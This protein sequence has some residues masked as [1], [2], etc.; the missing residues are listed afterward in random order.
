MAVVETRVVVLENQY[1]VVILFNWK[2]I[3]TQPGQGDMEDVFKSS[4]LSGL[5]QSNSHCFQDWDAVF[6]KDSFFR[7]FTII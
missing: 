5:S 6:T 3:I 7:S 4:M 2:R 1:R